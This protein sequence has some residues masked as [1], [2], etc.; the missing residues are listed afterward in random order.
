MKGKI[1]KL[2]S[3]IIF[4]ALIVKSV[5]YTTYL[6]RNANY[7]RLHII[8]MYEEKALD[9]VY[10]GG[11]SAFVYWQPLKAWNDCGFTSYS[12]ATNGLEVDGYLPYMEEVLERQRPRM[13]V[14]E[15]RGFQNVDFNFNEAALRNGTDS[16]DVFSM[17]RW[18]YVYNYMKERT[19]TEEMDKFS[20]Y[21][22]IAKYHT[23]IENLAKPEA[24]EYMDNRADCSN[25][26]WEWIDSWAEVSTPVGFE[27]DELGEI[28]ERTSDKLIELLE[29]CKSEKL[30][31]LF[32]VAPYVITKE[33]E[34]KYNKIS[35]VVDSY[36]YKFLNTNNY[37]KEM[38]LDFSTDFYNR[39][40]VN[41]FGAEKYTSFLEN[42]LTENYMLPAHKADAGYAL[43]NEEYER[44]EKEEMQ[45]KE[46]VSTFIEKAQKGKEIAVQMQLTDDFLEWSTLAEE[47][48]FTVLISEQGQPIKPDNLAEAQILEKWGISGNKRDVIRVISG[49]SVIYSNE[50]D[51]LTSYSGEYGSGIPGTANK[52]FT[53]SSDQETSF[54]EID[55]KDYCLGKD[56]LNVV[57]VDNN[58][59][60]IVDSVNITNQDGKLVLSRG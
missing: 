41:L 23:N 2:V 44:Y 51:C 25:K 42:Y 21:F 58:Y 39:N 54:I 9:M 11:S 37:Y 30:E 28:D 60:N 4:L 6:F 7:D 52:A 55:G 16:M 31:V 50:D 12:Y 14:V 22:D 24:W 19:I 43:W 59:L 45:H 5:T 3:C 46:I 29:F 17:N 57:V 56:G 48:Y 33:E 36:G 40:H 47:L 8:G 26:G 32:V 15:M 13:F 35:D 27:T 53:I 18:K 20:F 49:S 1:I 34:M 10:I 38:D